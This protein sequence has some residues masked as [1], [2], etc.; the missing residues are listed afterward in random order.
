MYPYKY[1][2]CI[3]MF[4]RRDHLKEHIAKHENLQKNICPEC[5]KAFQRKQHLNRHIRGN[6]ENE[7]HSCSTCSKTFTQKSNMKRHL[8]MCKTKEKKSSLYALGPD[9][10]ESPKMFV[11]QF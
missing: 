2:R 7:K 11:F 10:N 5:P 6:H 8:K 1:A 3:Q 4:K 9:L